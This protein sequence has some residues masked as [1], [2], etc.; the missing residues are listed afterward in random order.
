MFSLEHA[1]NDTKISYG[2]LLNILG[3]ILEPK[4]I[5]HTKQVVSIAY[6]NK[7]NHIKLKWINQMIKMWLVKISYQL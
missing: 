4:K 3:I 7:I 1:N 5:K 2:S 6:H